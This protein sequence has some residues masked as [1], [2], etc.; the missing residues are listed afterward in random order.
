MADKIQ[1]LLRKLEEKAQQEKELRESLRA[2]QAQVG[3][4]RRELETVK[5]NV[6][7]QMK[8]INSFFS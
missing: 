7:D 5:K 4:L 1:A 6:Q 2:S 8:K 3:S